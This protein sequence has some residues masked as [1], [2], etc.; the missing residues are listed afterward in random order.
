METPVLLRTPEIF[1]SNEILN[2]ALGD[3]VYCV[4]ESFI[5]TIS[6]KEYDLTLEWRFYNDGKAWFG[7]VIHIL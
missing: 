7:K 1:P 2:N 6:N 3:M 4:L 5:G